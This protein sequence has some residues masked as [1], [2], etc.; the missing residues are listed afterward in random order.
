MQITVEAVLA[1]MSF[2]VAMIGGFGTWMFRIDRGLNQLKTL[3]GEMQILRHENDK[4][5]EDIWD[6]CNQHGTRIGKHGEQLAAI[7]AQINHRRNQDE[8]D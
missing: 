3:T 7:R 8:H 2:L 6:T 1:I 5:H 4:E